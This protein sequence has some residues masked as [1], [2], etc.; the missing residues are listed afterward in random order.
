MTC[1]AQGR[2][3]RSC[4]NQAGRLFCRKRGAIVLAP[5]NTA[6]SKIVL[7][8]QGM[9]FGQQP[10]F[11]PCR[12]LNCDWYA[13]LCREARE[14]QRA[15]P[16]T[17]SQPDLGLAVVTLGPPLW[18][19]RAT[20]VEIPKGGEGAA[21]RRQPKPPDLPG[22]EEPVKFRTEGRVVLPVESVVGRMGGQAAL[23]M[24]VRQASAAGEHLKAGLCSRCR[25]HVW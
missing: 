18:P 12:M 20:R 6:A 4:G 2:N 15:A 19:E 13:V 22:P 5:I 9:R 16:Q 14:R 17:V 3:P 10:R 1:A 8:D 7:R 24:R 21:R 25:A 23:S 11:G